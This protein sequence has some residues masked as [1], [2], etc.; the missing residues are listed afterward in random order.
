MRLTIRSKMYAAFGLMIALLLLVSGYGFFTLGNVYDNGGRIAG[1]HVPRLNIAHQMNTLE[2]TYRVM[3]YRQ[4]LAQTPQE[5]DEHE[6]SM[7]A[8]AA[9]FET[10]L[11]E[12]EGKVRPENR[13]FFEAI[14]TKWQAFRAVNETIRSM[15]RE[16]KKQEA[17]VAMSGESRKLYDEISKDLLTLVN[18]NIQ[19]IATENNNNGDL[20]ANAKIILS[21]AILF[22]VAISILIAFLISRGINQGINEVLRVSEKVAGGDLR[23]RVKFDSSDE[24]GHLAVSYNSTLE[25]MKNLIKGIQETAEQVAASSEQLTASADQSAEVTTQIARSITSVA[26]ASNNQSG[27]VDTTSATVEQITASIEQVAANATESAAQAS[28]AAGRAKDGGESVKKAVAQMSNIEKKVSSSS[29]MVEKLG[30]RSK[31][32]GQIVNTISGIAGQTNL[33]A[34]N[35][36]IEAARAGEQGRGFAVVAEEVRKLAEQSQSAA[37]QIESL[38]GAIQIDTET[39]VVAMREGTQEVKVGTAVVDD[40]GRAFTEILH[41]VVKVSDQ[42]GEIA[43]TI[44]EVATGSEQIVGAIASIDSASKRVSQESQS[45]SAATEE[46][47]ASMEEIAASSQSLAKLAQQLQVDTRK[48]TL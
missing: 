6:K 3:Q 27:E 23:D 36:A 47:S 32:I 38:I 46:Q 2:A 13:A 41:L 1:E 26:E 33:L 31:E 11:K 25:N 39:A 8:T 45:V 42:V 35:A 37:K 14:K 29:E 44:N 22:T 30:E 40:S 5:M 34:L 4:I 24:I 19:F 17:M 43:K 21:S 15:S 28:E 48:F 10:L 16:N 18:N 20:F 12:F 9:E 7:K